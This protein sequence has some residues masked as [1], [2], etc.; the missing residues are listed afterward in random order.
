MALI[1]YDK[2]IT[3]IFSGYCGSDIDEFASFL[4]HPNIS[5]FSHSGTKIKKSR[6]DSDHAVRYD[7]ASHL[8]VI[9]TGNKIVE[10]KDIDLSVDV[11]FIN[12]PYS[13]L[14]IKS[15]IA[16]VGDGYNL[17]TR[18]ESGSKIDHVV[19]IDTDQ[20]IMDIDQLTVSIIYDQI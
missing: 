3:V 5:Y 7:V 18:F 14:N 19:S 2:P 17:N 10:I 13:K 11:L 6:E 15:K 20:L 8:G 9:L 1:K 16:I 12:A 4:N